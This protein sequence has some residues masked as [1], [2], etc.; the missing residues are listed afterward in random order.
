MLEDICKLRVFDSTITK[1]QTITKFI[2]GHSSVLSM[3]R[4]FTRNKEL[5]RPASNKLMDS[6]KDKIARSFGHL[7]AKYLSIWKRI[8]ARWN[9]QLHRPLLVAGYYLNPQFRYEDNF[10]CDEKVKAGLEACM[11][12]M[13]DDQQEHINA[14]LQLDLYDHKLSK[15]GSVMA[16]QT[17]KVRSPVW[18]W[19]KYGYSHVGVDEFAIR[20]LSLTCSASG[21]ERNWSTFSSIHTKN[22][23]R[24]EHERLSHLVYV[25]YNLAFRDRK[26]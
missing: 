12:R 13:I 15:F 17:R 19:E 3:M 10:S 16:L 25:K 8:D 21:C 11:G 9:P 18:W 7:E 2:Y 5:V 26:Y 24:L 20:V 4:G 14:E 22:R 6:A 23:N 1:A